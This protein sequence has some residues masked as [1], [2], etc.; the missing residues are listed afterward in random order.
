ML[1]G[2]A[3]LV[4]VLVLVLVLVRGVVAY[5]NGDRR[6]LL[7]SWPDKVDEALGFVY[8][9]IDAGRTPLLIMSDNAVFI[10]I[11]GDTSVGQGLLEG[12]DEL[13]DVVQS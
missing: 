11:S 6:V 4:V 10:M 5:S 13:V 7:F 1:P 12:C 3:E 2:K 9:S 8:S